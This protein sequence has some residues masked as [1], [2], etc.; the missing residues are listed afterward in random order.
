MSNKL[1]FSMRKLPETNQLL[2]TAKNTKEYLWLIEQM[3]EVVN[4]GK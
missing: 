2:I 3:D 4:D 1:D